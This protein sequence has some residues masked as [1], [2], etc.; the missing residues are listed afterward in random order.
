MP[1]LLVALCLVS[2]GSSALAAEQVPVV[3]L[4]DKLLACKK[5]APEKKLRLTLHGEV[6][7]Q[8]L[9]AALA[10]LSCRPIVIG[11]AA[12]HGGKVSIEAPDLLSP[13]EA[14]RLLISALDSLGLSIEA[15]GGGYR[16]F[17]SAR[18]KEI[19][20]A[21]GDGERGM[22][23]AFVVR[24]V[25]LNDASAEE[26]AATLG[27]IKSK[28]GEVSVLPQGRAI[29]IIDRAAQ[30]ERMEALARALDRPS[31]SA[32]MFV[33]TTH[34]T[35][36]SELV[37]ALD[38]IA[39]GAAPKSDKAD[40]L[41]PVLLP[42][43]AAR[44]ILFSGSEL[45]FQRVEA[46]L[47]RIDPPLLPGEERGG[48]IAVFYLKHVTAEDVAQTVKDVL[49]QARSA[50]P[51]APGLGG[52]GAPSAGALEGEVRVTADKVGNSLVVSG[53]AADLE[54]VRELVARLD[55]P[56]RQVYLEAV[57]LDLSADLSR[58]VGLSLHQ[59]AASSSGSVAGFAASTS[60]NGL[61]GVVVDPVKLGTALSGGGLLAGVLGKS[62]DVAGMSVPSFGVVLQ[63]I[64]SS[65][66]VSVLSRP[67]ILTMD[68]NKASISVGQKIPFPQ[69]SITT[70]VGS[71]QNSYVRQ[72]VVLKMDLTPHLSDE[73]E[74]RLEIDGEID[75]VVPGTASAGGPTTNQRSIKT[76]VVVQD[77][78]T[79]VLGGLQKESATDSV[80][81]VPLLGDIPILGRLFQTRSK[82][83]GKQDLLIILTPYV[84]RDEADLCRIRERREQ[85]RRELA[86][87]ATMFRDPTA[88]DLHVDY[89]RKR[90]LLEEINLAARAV[91]DERDALARAREALQP[92]AEIHSGE[93][94]AAPPTDPSRGRP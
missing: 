12:L 21:L 35:R 7:A 82:Q 75:E 16:V 45:A 40:A 22:R 48:R 83:R 72:D 54:S 93:V 80:D 70:A 41:R 94:L 49:T 29:L 89:R 87:R 42:V 61:N 8:E 71:V 64:E 33:L 57:V 59:G 10:P 51:S 9:V 37:E 31:L 24:L 68:H 62:F 52:P 77:G 2:I 26:V 4:A 43:D 14:T 69:A 58:A 38:K 32:R 92:H 88:Y 6:G 39:I 27:K 63:A 20:T 86:E 55:L 44:V 30:V 56:R 91:A 34:R 73:H 3:E 67:H 11:G 25:R 19:A 17:D 76:T 5:L 18:G 85:E 23:E 46:L 15:A 13:M 79:V 53:S 84:I 81:K 50:R 1:R 47:A 65:R 28:E 36:P 90:G 60:S 66:D 74:I 78:E